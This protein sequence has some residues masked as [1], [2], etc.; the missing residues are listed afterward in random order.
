MLP[1]FLQ[2]F[3]P[4]EETHWILPVHSKLSQKEQ[5]RIFDRPPDGVRKI[6]LATNI[7]ETSLTVRQFVFLRVYH[8]I[9][10]SKFVLST[11]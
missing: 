5:E 8:L 11:D 6:V 2:E 4:T 7:A 9:S 10:T 1:L 3:Y